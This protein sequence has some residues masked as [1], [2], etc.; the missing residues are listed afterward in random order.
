MYFETKFKY[1]LLLTLFSTYILMLLGAYTKAIGAGLACPDWP[2][3]YGVW[4]PFLHPEIVSNTSFTI[5]QIFVEWIHRGW[6]VIVGL[7]ILFCTYLS[8]KY[9]DKDV[10]IF[11]IITILL[12]PLQIILGGLTVTE[13]L[14]PLIVTSHL[15]A[16]T[17][18]ILFLTFA[19]AITWKNENR[20]ILY[21]QSRIEKNRD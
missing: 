5:H 17:L 4:I 14:E 12:L 18:I 21:S 8:F 19:T 15:G 3:C 7:L 16:A 9:N 20:G 13:N 6:A 10:K 2:T 1:L 11:L